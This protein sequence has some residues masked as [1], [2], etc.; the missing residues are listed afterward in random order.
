MIAL[1]P[2]DDA[3]ALHVFSDLDVND[4]LE[5][6]LMLGDEARPL[7]LWAAWRAAGPASLIAVRGERAFAVMALTPFAV[8]AATVAMLARDHRRWRAELRQLVRH[9]RREWPAYAA[10]RGVTR[11]ECRSWSGHPTAGRLLAAIGFHLEARLPGFAGG[12]VDFD[13][14]AWIRED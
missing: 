7:P 12:G 2:W 11:A 3:L 5:A 6:Q 13:Q 4:A 8:G 1:R 9:W 10:A 14:Y